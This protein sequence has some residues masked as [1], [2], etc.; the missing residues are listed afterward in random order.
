MHERPQAAAKDEKK[1]LDFEEKSKV[2]QKAAAPL[3]PVQEE[4][5]KRVEEKETQ[6]NKVEIREDEQLTEPKKE[7]KRGPVIL[8]TSEYRR[9]FS[10]PAHYV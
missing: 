3:E 2:V 7:E 10:P 5:K 8:V 4:I 6:V 9:S 1:K